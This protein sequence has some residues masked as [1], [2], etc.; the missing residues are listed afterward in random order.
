MY[1][2]GPR[3][4]IAVVGQAAGRELTYRPVP[5]Q[6][7]GEQLTGFGV[8]LAEAAFL[9]ELFEPL[10]DGRNA[11]LST[12]VQDV[13]GRAPRDFADVAR[14]AAGTGVWKS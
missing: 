2:A 4:A 9:V 1:G 11:Y 3:E 14:E 5:A 8:P 12:G 13:L 6:Q 7:Y 10:L